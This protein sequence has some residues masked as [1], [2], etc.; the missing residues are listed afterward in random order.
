MVDVRGGVGAERDVEK[1][2]IQP[3]GEIGVNRNIGVSSRIARR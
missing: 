3:A 1:G 2:E